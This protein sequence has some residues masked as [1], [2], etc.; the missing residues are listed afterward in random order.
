MYWLMGDVVGRL[1]EEWYMLD[2]RK[3]GWKEIVRVCIWVIRV[4]EAERDWI[5]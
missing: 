5:S 1:G 3:T 2:S 4:T